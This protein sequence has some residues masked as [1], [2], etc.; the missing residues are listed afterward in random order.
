MPCYL[1]VLFVLVCAG[2]D[3]ALAD[4]L[5][6]RAD[7]GASMMHPEEGRG[8]RIV[9]FRPGSVLEAAG[10]RVNDEIES[11]ASSRAPRVGGD[12]ARDAEAFGGFIRNARAGDVVT[13]RVKRAGPGEVKVTLPPL[14]EESVDGADVV[15]GSVDTDKG[16]RVR[17][18]TSRPRGATG[19]LPVVVFIPWLSCGAV[20]NPMAVSESGAP[21]PAATRSMSR[22]VEKVR[23]I[24]PASPRRRKAWRSSRARKAAAR[25]RWVWGMWVLV[26]N[27]A[28]G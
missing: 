19:R 2:C 15:Y 14:R 6:R 9:R 24:P 26:R 7:F 13:L 27:P 17:T 5:P 21:R 12:P 10:F 4:G 28:E 23:A 1:A 25:G 22:E 11:L 18:Y 3:T 16:Y 20:E 8:P